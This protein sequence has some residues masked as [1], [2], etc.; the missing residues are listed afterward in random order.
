MTKRSA[1]RRFAALTSA[2]AAIVAAS[3]LAHAVPAGAQGAGTAIDVALTEEPGD[4][5]RGRTIVVD[6]ILSACV[7]CHALPGT[8]VSGNLGPSLAGVGSRLSVG[9]LRS[10]LV[11]SSRYNPDTVMPAYYLTAGLNRVAATYRDKPIL[12][13]QQIEDVVAYLRTLK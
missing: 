9:E 13:A 8:E 1:N 3:A 5:T 7:L 11:D 4:A 12:S 2:L 10:R 6:R